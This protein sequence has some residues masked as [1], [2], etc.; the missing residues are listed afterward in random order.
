M[1][2][3]IQSGHCRVLLSLKVLLYKLC[4]GTAC[5]KKCKELFEYQPNITL[6]VFHFYHH[7]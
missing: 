4:N 1:C 2:R 3:A 6:N 7:C 5:F